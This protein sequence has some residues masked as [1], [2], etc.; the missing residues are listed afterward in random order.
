V[1]FSFGGDF[2]R[3]FYIVGGGFCG[4]FHC[5]MFW[6]GALMY[7]YNFPITEGFTCYFSLQNFLWELK[8]KY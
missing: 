4:H 1:S 2:A 6:G 8:E 5:G 3:T 7:S